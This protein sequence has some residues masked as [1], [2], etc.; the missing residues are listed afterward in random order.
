MDGVAR[1]PADMVVRC[2]NKNSCDIF[3]DY[4][5]ALVLMTEGAKVYKKAHEALGNQLPAKKRMQ[6]CAHF[7]ANDMCR[8]GA[9][10]RFLHVLM[11]AQEL[12]ERQAARLRRAQQAEMEGGA[13][14]LAEDED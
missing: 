2:Y 11:T 6:H 12:E 14:E 1:L 3:N 4:P 8:L 5:G 9:S 10:C 7:R 13:D